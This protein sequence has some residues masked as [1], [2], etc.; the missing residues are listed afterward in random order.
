M[1]RKTFNPQ[2][3]LN[4]PTPRPKVTE[5][6]TFNTDFQIDEVGR[7]IQSIEA[8]KTDITST[9]SDW[10][11]IGF[12]FSDE[13]GENGRTLFHRVSQFYPNYSTPECDKQFDNC[14]KSKGHGVSL[15][16]FF[17]FA[18]NAGIEIAPLRTEKQDRRTFKSEKLNGSQSEYH[19]P[20]KQEPEKIPTF[21]DSLFPELPEFLQKVVAVA[22][23]NEERDIL[24]LGSLG[25]ISACLSKVSGIY[26]GKRVF[27]NLFLFITAQASAGKGRLV[28]CRQLVNTIHKELR[29]QAKLHKQRYELEIAEYNSKK[30]KDEGIEKPAK[31]PEKMLFIPANNSSTGAY[32]LLGDSDGR[33]LIFETEGDTLAHAFKSDYGNYS[34]GFRK[35]F[36]HETISY[37]RRTDREFV[38]IES[39]CLSTVLSGTPMQVSALIPNVENGLFSRFIFYFMN[40]RPVWKNVFASQMDNGLDDYFEALGNEFYELY[41]VIMQDEPRQFC[42]TADQQEQFN[43]FFGQIQEKYMSL[44]GL[45]YLATIRRLGLIAYRISMIFSALRIMETGDTSKK[46]ICE[47]RDFRASL[48]IVKVLVKHSSKVFGELPQEETKPTRLNRKEKF[49]CALPRTFNRQEYLEAAEAQGIPAKTAEGYISKFVKSRLIHR[50][51]HDQYINTSLEEIQDS[52]EVKD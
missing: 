5:Q 13:F 42:L 28:H 22:T 7:I 48:S 21:P 8:N 47:E 25:A 4:Q 23:S 33:G 9:Y 44:Q 15:K 37:Y 30:G 29:E 38:D 20:E 11:N 3:W 27:P 35:A 41:K 46:L 2:D 36:H 50:E 6:Q 34:D 24:L 31:P 39:P 32:Q 14:L 18:K 1:E 16:T 26:D 19:Q 52:L 49:L 45:E 12:A 43:Q 10:V 51:A 40:V 17:Y